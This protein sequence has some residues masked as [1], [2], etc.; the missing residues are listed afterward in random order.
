LATNSNTEPSIGKDHF[1]TDH[2]RS[3][4]KTRALR[5]A[6]ATIISQGA[7]FVIQTIGTVILARLLT[8]ED[9]G[10]VTMVLTFSLL[11]QNFG[12]NGFTEAIIQK[13]VIDHRQIS[14]L[15]WINAGCS[16]ILALLFIAFAPVMVW[17]YREPRLYP[18]IL[19]ISASIIFAGLSTQHLALL[20]RGMQFGKIAVN[21]TVGALISISVP[22]LLAWWGWGYQALVAKWVLLPFASA[23]GAWMLCGWRPGP[24]ARDAGVKPMLRYAFHTYGNFVMNYFRRNLDK[25]LIGRFLGSQQL[26]YY[27]RAYH[28][29]SLLPGQLIGPLHS[30][31][32]S[33]F[34]RLADD[35]VKLRESYLKALSILAFVGMPLGAALTLVAHDVTLLLLG[36]QW[37]QTGEMFFAFGLSIGVS[38]IY[39]THGWLHLTLGTPERWFRW[40]IVEFAATA[41]CFAAGLPF[42]A[43]G[44]AVAYSASI[45]LLLGPALWYAGKPIQLKVSLVL[46]TLWKYYLAALAAGSLCWAVI[47]AGNAVS[48]FFGELYPLVRI[49]ISVALC[50]SIYL[51]MV[52][53]LFWNFS[54]ISQFVS[55]LQEMIANKSRPTETQ[56]E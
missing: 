25:I 31:A 18:I 30:V 54:P 5:G 8:P 43:L 39:L 41:L 33:T 22:V 4:L 17:F 47:H 42:G 52:V 46:S 14:T 10:L 50:S 15:F 55:I 53:L 36:P 34:S 37:D 12:I 45:Y 2:L 32:V 38:I 20:K 6:T 40:G 27:D 7:S 21:E 1:S 56:S 24:P 3:G 13:E 51:V 19:S 9:F 23:A 44:V 26:G 35:P 29:S 48:V 11:L 16:L 28:L 49:I